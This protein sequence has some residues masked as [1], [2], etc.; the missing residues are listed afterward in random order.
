MRS[1]WLNKYL[2]QNAMFRTMNVVM[3]TKA[4]GM[5]VSPPRITHQDI[6]ALVKQATMVHESVRAEMLAPHPRKIPPRFTAAQI[7]D[8]CAMDRTKLENKLRG[9]SFPSGSIAEGKRRRTY[10]L[11]DVRDIV[12]RL[13]PYAKREDGVPGVAIACVNFKGGSSKTSTV[14]NIAQG[15]ALR[16]RRVL[17]IDLDPQASASIL[18]GLMPATELTEADTASMLVGNP[19]SDAQK[20]LSYAIRK[21]YWDGLDIVPA[22]SQLNSA[23]M[24]L[25]LLSTDLRNRWWDIMNDAIQGHRHEY[26]YILFDT[27]PSL[28]FLGMLAIFASDGLLMPLPPEQLDFSASASF[29]DMVLEFMEG[30]SEKRDVTKTFKMIGVVLS[31]VSPRPVSA[32]MKSFIQRAYTEYVLTTE[33]PLSEANAIGGLTFGTAHDLADDDGVARTNTKLRQSFDRL[34]E[35]LDERVVAFNWGEI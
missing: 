21:T 32:M 26:D 1:G 25:P 28:S 11:S 15:L 4:H 24:I 7:A 31:K 10:S 14:F 17:L 34:V 12:S 22:T 8:L 20:D 9:P 19:L 33:V 23:E 18:T 30:L 2:Q 6:R 27:A 29:W 5:A 3:L 13:G 16:G 35:L